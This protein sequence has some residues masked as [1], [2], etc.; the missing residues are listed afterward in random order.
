MSS[1]A[2]RPAAHS[3]PSTPLRI[4]TSYLNMANSGGG[5]VINGN[6]SSVRSA[7]SSAHMSSASRHLSSSG[8]RGRGVIGGLEAG[9]VVSIK[10]GLP[11][12]P[13]FV[14]TEPLSV[15][16]SNSAVRSN[17]EG[18]DNDDCTSNSSTSMYPSANVCT[19]CRALIQVNNRLNL[20]TDAPYSPTRKCYNYLD[21]NIFPSQQPQQQQQQQQSTSLPTTPQST[22]VKRSLLAR[23]I[24][25]NMASQLSIN[26][27]N[28]QPSSS[29]N[30]LLNRSIDN[31]DAASMVSNNSAVAAS[32]LAADISISSSPGD[33]S[34]MM[35][36]TDI[37]VLN[38]SAASDTSV[39]S[40]LMA[41]AMTTPE[42]SPTASSKR[43]KSQQ[44]LDESLCGSSKNDIRFDVLF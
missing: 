30:C 44:L 28:T 25:N 27:F 2:A 31:N 3:R 15:E 19:N 35:A 33:L 22:Q 13:K 24:K 17:N 21:S 11:M 5:C 10:S 6:N 42:G 41:M 9:S 1:T 8:R 32:T 43:T 18:P 34:G 20:D 7:L 23:A 4:N 38:E 39:S 12:V 26:L 14:I 37:E 36:D 16:K 29:S 40:E